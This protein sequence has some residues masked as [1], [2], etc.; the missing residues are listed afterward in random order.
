ML[1]FLNPPNVINSYPF[2]TTIN[3]SK[4]TCH[5]HFSKK[6]FKHFELV[7]TVCLQDYG[8]PI[9]FYFDN[10]IIVCISYNI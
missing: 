1:I 2:Y 8:I 3:E 9:E 6:T 5:F 7:N 4:I 10:I